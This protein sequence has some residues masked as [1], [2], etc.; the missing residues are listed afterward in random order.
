MFLSIFFLVTLSIYSSDVFVRT[1]DMN[2]FS[3]SICLSQKLKKD[4]QLI[5]SLIQDPI[6]EGRPIELECR[7]KTLA[8][9]ETLLQSD[10]HKICLPVKRKSLIDLYVVAHQM[11]ISQEYMRAI[12]RELCYSMDEF[13]KLPDAIKPLIKHDIALD[14]DIQYQLIKSALASKL[15]TLTFGQQ[16]TVF[17]KKYIGRFD[18]TY[19]EEIEVTETKTFFINRQIKKIKRTL[20]TRTLVIYSLEKLFQNINN[21]Q[22]AVDQ[23]ELGL[24]ATI[25]LQNKHSTSQSLF[26]KSFGKFLFVCERSKPGCISVYDDFVKLADF[27]TS[28]SMKIIA[29]NHTCPNKVAWVLLYT[30]NLLEISKKSWGGT[31]QNNLAFSR[32]IGPSALYDLLFDKTSN[33]YRMVYFS[34]SV[35]NGESITHVS[36]KNDFDKATQQRIQFPSTMPLKRLGLAY[37]NK[38]FFCRFDEK[39]M[40]K[41]FIEKESYIIK[42]FH[43]DCKA[44]SHYAG[45]DLSTNGLI[46]YTTVGAPGNCVNYIGHSISNLDYL[47]LGNDI[48]RCEIF[49]SYLLKHNYN[50]ITISSLKPLMKL[51][52][53]LF[54]Q[55]KTE[56]VQEIHNNNND[57]AALK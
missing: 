24:V 47:N 43:N 33:C 15:P 41:G 40:E 21:P 30:G 18:D 39:K 16:F 29:F 5:Q 20:E 52:K 56:K 12:Q 6:Y 34:P 57:V 13:R 55:P 3:S 42:H 22:G 36:W 46:N 28:T 26:I 54:L 53:E 1:T 44:K 50:G 17:D 38:I 9:L 25:P 10:L 7:S 45:F 2:A 35:D 4:S 19:K 31:P 23:I 27:P 48:L 14:A 37:G 32:D 49:G 8:S 11:Q 51:Y